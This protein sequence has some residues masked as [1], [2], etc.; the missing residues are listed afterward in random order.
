MS[1]SVRS[2]RSFLRLAV[3]GVSGAAV[4]GWPAQ[5]VL[6]VRS[7]GAVGNGVTIDTAA[8]NR[9]I[10]VAARAGGA[11]VH[12]SAGIYAC[13][14][15]HLKSHVTLSL[16]P[17]ATIL[18]A[19]AGGYDPAEPNPWDQ[20]QDFGHS[21]FHDSLICGE[22]VH[23]IAILGPGRIWGRGLSRDAIAIDGQPSALA[24]KA[25]DKAIALKN[26]YNV[27]LRDFSILAGGHFAV[28]ATGVDDLSIENL[29]IDTNR[30]GI[31]IDSCRKV[32][33]SN[34]RVNSPHD[35]SI[36][37]K[38]SLALGYP[39]ATEDVTI[40]N[41]YVTGGYR[42]GAM[43]DGSGMRL[44]S[45]GESVKARRCMMG[46]IKLGT[47][48]NGGFRN[49]TIENCVCESCLGLAVETVDGGDLE[50]VVIRDIAMRDIR[51]APIFLR[52][53]A[54][55]RGPPGTRTGALRGVAISN[56]TCYAPASDVPAIISGIPGHP[57]DVR[58]MHR[59]GGSKLLTRVVPPEEE[60]AYPETDM[61][62]PLP[63]QGLFA[64]H[65]RNIEI[66]RVA[67]DS[68]TPD[69]RP[70]LWLED[71]VGARVSNLS[72]PHATAAPAIARSEPH[73]VRVS[74]SPTARGPK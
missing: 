39:R 52:L 17:G 25:A 26:C 24:P 69:A 74:G 19:P 72:L 7:F 49:I 37:L 10:A 23:D 73:E 48:S 61:F 11:I 16:A 54:R 59:G 64:R 9:A 31:N 56:L 35:D 22:G 70:F 53:G 21:H 6:D 12:F 65:V 15:I 68:A 2:R 62:G 32:R 44:A 63:A 28:L 66:T 42:V 4:L 30:D 27:T 71:A 5:N 60:N 20:Y 43:L 40:D 55:L 1:N 67:F 50:N 58:L 57:V 45:A 13:H 33:V 51:G 14:S 47:E 46:R 18:A 3:S 41:C 8:V 34:C 36:C 29:T 38:S